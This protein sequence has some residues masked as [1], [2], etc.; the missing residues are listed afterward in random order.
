MGLFMLSLQIHD[1]ER[2][3]KPE[4]G[5]GHHGPRTCTSSGNFTP[6]KGKEQPTRQVLHTH[7]EYAQGEPNELAPE[8]VH[9]SRQ[10][11]PQT[12]Y[13]LACVMVSPTHA[14]LQLT[15]SFLRNRLLFETLRPREDAA[16][17]VHL[18]KPSADRQRYECS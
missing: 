14:R 15:G 9:T 16:F 3:K 8:S 4:G 18:L 10:P 5:R 2:Y 11:R 12:W 1:V 13:P 6:I 7:G 17:C